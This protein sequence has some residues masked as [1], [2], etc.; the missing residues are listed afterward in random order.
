MSCKIVGQIQ[1]F[2]YF[3]ML[4]GAAIFFWTFFSFWIFYDVLIKIMI[5]GEV[6]L[7]VSYLQYYDNSIFTIYKRRW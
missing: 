2:F 3:S 5:G 4:G 6:H 7:K 1:Y